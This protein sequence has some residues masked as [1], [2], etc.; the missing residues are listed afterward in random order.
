MKAADL[1]KRNLEEAQSLYHRFRKELRQDPLLQEGLKALRE[2]LRLSEEAYQATGAYQ[3]C[4]ICALRYPST[5]CGKDM[6]LE[7]S[8]EL[9]VLNLILGMELPQE[10]AFSEACFFL[11]P[12]GCRLWA[13]PILCRNFF[14]PWFREN[15]DLQKLAYLQKIQE[16]ELN[17]LFNLLNRLKIFLWQVDEPS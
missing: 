14:C 2:G 4:Q 13:R 9:L 11:G 10:P 7:V 16:K 12:K 3:L 17:S 1:L 8:R 6:E 5:C 15:F